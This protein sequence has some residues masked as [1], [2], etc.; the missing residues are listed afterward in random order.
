MWDNG[1]VM[2]KADHDEVRGD[3]VMHRG[4]VDGYAAEPSCRL[5]LRHSPLTGWACAP[6]P[7]PWACSRC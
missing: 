4:M 2:H 5:E 1:C 3:R 6:H 7:G